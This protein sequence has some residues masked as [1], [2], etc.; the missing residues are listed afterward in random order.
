[1]VPHPIRMLVTATITAA[2]SVAT[3]PAMA[4]PAASAARPARP[5]VRP[6]HARTLADLSQS[7]RGEAFANASYQLFSAESAREG[8]PGA[9]ALFRRTAR[10]ELH[11]HFT[12]EAAQRGLV[13]TDAADLRAAISGETYESRVMYP[14][15]AR[16]ARRNG[17][18]AAAALFTEA[19]RDEAAH[20]KAFA[21]ALRVLRTGRGRIPAPPRLDWVPVRAGLPKAASARTREDLDTAMHG[22]AL[23]HARYTLYA[24]HARRHGHPALARLLLGTAAVELHEHFAAEAALAGLVRSA[25]TDLRTATAGERYES[26]TMYPAFAVQAMAAGD[27]VAARLFRHNARDEAQHARAFRRMLLAL[28]RR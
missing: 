20:R 26:G 2:A 8:L 19:A 27:R 11:E 25:R 16:R 4:A 22:E 6:L 14:L 7:M 10:V 9:A 23:A 18:A 5:A 15:F 13:G 3:C 24:D 28:R 17:D 1:M 12:E 21:A